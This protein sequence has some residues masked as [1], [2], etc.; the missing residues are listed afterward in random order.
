MADFAAELGVSH[1][2]IL[3]GTGLEQQQLLDPNMLVT[4]QQELQLIRNLVETFSQ[5]P[6]LGLEV[7]QR[8][9]FTTF[10]SLGLGLIS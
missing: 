4:G 2:Q 3:K 9:H 1:A 6:S 7:G 5:R 10:G 8:Y